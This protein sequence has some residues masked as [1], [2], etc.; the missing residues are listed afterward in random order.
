MLATA[1]QNAKAMF[2]LAKAHEGA[3]ELGKAS[4]VLLA[5][6]G[7]FL[8]RWSTASVCVGAAEQGVRRRESA[9]DQA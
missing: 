2:R 3:G 1:P 8:R 9:R 5:I 6:T 4:A 7:R